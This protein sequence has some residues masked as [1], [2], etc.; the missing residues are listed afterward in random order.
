M[1][2]DLPEVRRIKRTSSKEVVVY[3]DIETLDAKETSLEVLRRIYV[4]DEL[5]VNIRLAAAKEALPYEHSK[6]PIAIQEQPAG[7][8]SNLLDLVRRLGESVDE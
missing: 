3:D 1:K 4:D 7:D 5:P 2:K 8:T 6:K